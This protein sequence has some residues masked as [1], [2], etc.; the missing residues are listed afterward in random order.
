MLDTEATLSFWQSVCSSTD[1]V[2]SYGVQ[3]I[4]YKLYFLEQE[5]N[6]LY[7]HMFQISY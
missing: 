1:F 7:L 4:K 6:A 3:H 2:E 5:V